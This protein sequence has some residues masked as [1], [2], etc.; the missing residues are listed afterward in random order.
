MGGTIL[1][2][3]GVDKHADRTRLPRQVHGSVERLSTG[4]QH[5]AAHRSVP[6]ADVG[7]RRERLLSLCKGWQLRGAIHLSSL[8]VYLRV[9]GPRDS[10]P[11]LIVELRSWTELRGW[12][13]PCLESGDQPYSRMVVRVTVEPLGLDQGAGPTLEPAGM[14]ERIA[15]RQARILQATT[16]LPGS[17][18]RVHFKPVN[19][20]LE[21]DGG[22]LLQALNHRV[23]HLGTGVWEEECSLG[24][25]V[26]QGA[27]TVSASHVVRA[28]ERYLHRFASAVEP[29]VNPRVRILH[30]DEALVVVDKPAPLPMHAGGRFYQNTLQHI[31]DAAYAPEKPRPAHRID[32]NTTGLLLV[33]RDRRFA[34]RLQPQFARGEVQKQYLVRVMGHPAEDRFASDLPITDTSGWRGA[35]DVALAGGLPARTEFTLLHRASDG[36]ALL[37]ARPRTG[38]THQI[39][40]HLW[41]L[42]FPILGDPVY[43]DDGGPG[44]AQTLGIDDPPLCLHAWRIAFRHPLTGE[45]AQFEAPRPTWACHS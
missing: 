13:V 26:N 34:A 25:I 12:E 32:A 22:T 9:C 28:G 20:P 17:H 10:I 38:R 14:A 11:L 6:L 31:L 7:P 23:S 1:E 3:P 41:K 43:R 5:I 33:T 16:P 27:E 15:C 44:T 39:R 45:P 35:R 4:Y 30:E 2:T 29:D 21:C 42:G 36:T 37:E 24:R 40:I 8:G 18:P 19:I